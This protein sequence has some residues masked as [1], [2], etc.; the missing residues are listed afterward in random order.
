[1]YRRS[2]ASVGELVREQPVTLDFAEARLYLGRV[3][4]SLRVAKRFAV[5]LLM[6]EE[7]DIFNLP[8]PS[9]FVSFVVDSRLHLLS[10]HLIQTLA[11]VSFVQ[12]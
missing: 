8:L 3:V 2:R 6:E 10:Y 12:H 11:A 5:Q 4:V 1:M 7:L 9:S